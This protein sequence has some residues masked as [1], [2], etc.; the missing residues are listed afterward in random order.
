MLLFDRLNLGSGFRK[1]FAIQPA[2]DA[3]LC[4]QVYR[5]RHEV[6]CEE[7]GFAPVHPDRREIDEYDARSLH[8]LLRTR[9]NPSEPVGCARVIFAQAGASG[10]SLPFEHICRMTLDRS[11]INPE[12]LHRGSIAEI[13]RLAVRAGWRRRQGESRASAPIQEADFGTAFHPRF[14]YI[15]ISLCLGALALA[16]RSGIETLFVL[17]EPRLASHF[18]KLGVD[19]RQIGGAVEHHGTRIPSMMD[20]NGIIKGMRFLLKPM[21]RTIQEEIE[22]GYELEASAT[23]VRE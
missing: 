14:P 10:C 12:L 7:F 20:V 8:C 4:N 21:W 19:V 11:I 23:G 16:S 5:T 6:Y 18:A 3:T 9:S 2:T 15:P 22:T 17:T 13:S 1:Y